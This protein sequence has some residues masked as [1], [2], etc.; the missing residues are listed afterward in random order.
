ML[1]WSL[2]TVVVL[3]REARGTGIGTF[4]RPTSPECRASVTSHF[5][6]PRP[7]ADG[8]RRRP[9][10][11][12]RP[13]GSGVG[14]WPGLLHGRGDRSPAQATV[15]PACQGPLTYVR[16]P[17]VTLPRCQSW[18]A[19]TRKRNDRRWRGIVL[20]PVADMENWVFCATFFDRWYLNSWWHTKT[21][22]IEKMKTT[23]KTWS[24]Q[25]NE[26]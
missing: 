8:A 25:P 11:Q 20:R 7:T 16:F 6:R 1:K 18:T 24:T 5:Q 2:S 12:H 21:E 19:E 9:A 10:E 14:G 15:G 3:Q 22:K 4:S 13:C 17:E 26:K 23:T